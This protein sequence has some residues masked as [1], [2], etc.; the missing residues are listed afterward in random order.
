MLDPNTEFSPRGEKDR[1]C[2]DVAMARSS[3]ALRCLQGQSAL[4][5]L[6]RQSHQAPSCGGQKPKRGENSGPGKER[7]RELD[8]RPG[9]R[10]QPGSNADLSFVAFGCKRLKADPPAS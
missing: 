1:P 5:T 8:L 9:I 7:H 3:L 6:I 4:H 10:E 2:R